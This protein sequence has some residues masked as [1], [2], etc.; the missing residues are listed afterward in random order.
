MTQ[1]TL[2]V[3]LAAR[4]PGFSIEKPETAHTNILA[5]L[6]RTRPRHGTIVL[7][8]VYGRVH[9]QYFSLASTVIVAG[10][11]S[12]T[13]GYPNTH[14]GQ[15]SVSTLPASS[16]EVCFLPYVHKTPAHC[17]YPTCYALKRLKIHQFSLTTFLDYFYIYACASNWSYIEVYLLQD[18]FYHSNTNTTNRL[19]Q[20]LNITQSH[21][22][23]YKTPCSSGGNFY[24]LL[25][26]VM[27]FSSFLPKLQKSFS[28]CACR[29][30][31]RALLRPAC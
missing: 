16:Q 15:C 29:W 9:R 12:E 21:A 30:C 1:G 28:P 20:N 25:V 27:A 14:P 4:L 26:L 10:D 24:F 5:R 7:R 2:G 17:L 31:V 13:S 19:S 3:Y 6:G 8:F 23:I 18:F 11:V 22:S